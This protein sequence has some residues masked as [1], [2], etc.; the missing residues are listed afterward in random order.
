MKTFFVVSAL[1]EDSGPLGKLKR[2]TT[3][4]EAIQH[5]KDVIEMRRQNGQA[6]MSF[7]VLKVQAQVEVVSP[8]MKVTKA[9]G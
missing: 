6:Y 4:K 3:E 2:H 7:Y 8:P 9:R 5:A 1:R